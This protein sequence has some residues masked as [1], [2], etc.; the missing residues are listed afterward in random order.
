MKL[1]LDEKEKQNGEL[2][3]K[4]DEILLESTKINNENCQLKF[5]VASLKSQIETYKNI[6]FIKKNSSAVYETKLRDQM[7]KEGK[8][9]PKK[10]SIILKQRKNFAKIGWRLKKNRFKTR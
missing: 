8:F 4:I 6:A 7:E 1:S 9:I 2:S 5:E 10:I 3:Q